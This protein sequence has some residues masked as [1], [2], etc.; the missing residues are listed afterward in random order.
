MLTRIELR[1]YKCFRS[2]DIRPSRLC[3]IV[4]PNNSGKSSVLQ[5]LSQLGQTTSTHL[6]EVFKAPY[7]PQ[8]LTWAGASAMGIGF[9]VEV[10]TEALKSSSYVLEVGADDRGGPT[11]LSENMVVEGHEIPGGLTQRMTPSGPMPAT[12]LSSGERDRTRPLR[13][14]IGEVALVRFDPAALASPCA[15]EEGERGRTDS[16]GH[17]LPAV[18][19]FRKG[20]RLALF[21][22]IQEAFIKAFPEVQEIAVRKRVDR[23][24][25]RPAITVAIFFRTVGGREIPAQL[26]SEGMLLYLGYLTLLYS[27]KAPR[28]LLIEAPENG[29]HPRRIG[30]VVDVLRKITRDEGGAPPVQILM[31]THSP[32]IL[33]FLEPSEVLVATR[34]PGEP[35]IVASLS[36]APH[37]AERLQDFSLGELWYNVGEAALVK[38]RGR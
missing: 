30:Q 13:E 10:E 26:A 20:E 15:V 12:R 6:G 3:A 4:G 31:T 9:S 19:D 5:A 18:L 2:L 11:V 21:M 17:G 36:D 27:E 23:S 37:L 8:A 32:Y 33:D 25:K 16:N 14:A 28:L 34:E 22:A 38:G 7:D 1:N 24:A 29:N 35:A